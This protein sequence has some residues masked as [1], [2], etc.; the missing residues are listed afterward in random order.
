MRKFSQ[1]VAS[2]GLL[3]VTGASLPE[4][5]VGVA[6]VIAIGAVS[7]PSAA[8]AQNQVCNDQ[9]GLGGVGSCTGVSAF[10]RT[11]VTRCFRFYLPTGTR[12]FTTSNGVA[13]GLGG[14]N[15][16]DTIQYSIFGS[17]CGG[18][19]VRTASFSVAY[20]NFQSVDIN[21]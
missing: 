9:S 16:G 14:L 21:L 8:F 1:L 10:N 17:T 5:S 2:L 11:G 4:L 20:S 12:Q 19:A 6:S 13:M 7:I 3:A 15:P 18:S